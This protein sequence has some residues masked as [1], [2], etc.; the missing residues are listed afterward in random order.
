ML[1]NSDI[2]YR[3]DTARIRFSFVTVYKDKTLR[4]QGQSNG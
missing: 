2:P 1:V 4:E 3:A